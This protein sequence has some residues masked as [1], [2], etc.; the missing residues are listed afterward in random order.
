MLNQNIY[1]EEVMKSVAFGMGLLLLAFSSAQAATCSQ[2]AAAC[3][4]KGGSQAVCYEASR[5]ASCK[6]TGS[7][8]GPSGKSWAAKKGSN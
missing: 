5:M 3:M 4:K 8:V 7:Y 1:P 6:A 2:Q